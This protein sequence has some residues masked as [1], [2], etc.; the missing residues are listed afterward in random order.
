MSVLFSGSPS[1][2]ISP[3]SGSSK[4]I[5]SCIRLDLPL[6]LPPRMATVRCAGNASDTS[7][8]A[9]TLPRVRRIFFSSTASFG[10]ARR[11]RKR[12]EFRHHSEPDGNSKWPKES[13]LY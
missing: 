9:T 1:T 3:S 8:S 11:F 10:I 2:N 12:V 6:P 4:P 13:E 7:S 5:M